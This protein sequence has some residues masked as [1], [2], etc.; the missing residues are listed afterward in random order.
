MCHFI[1][2]SGQRSG[3]SGL[4]LSSSTAVSSRST[5]K[6]YS[7]DESGMHSWNTDWKKRNRQSNSVPTNLHQLG[8]EN[9]TGYNY[10]NSHGSMKYSYEQENHLP[11]QRKQ[12]SKS[13][14]QQRR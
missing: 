2:Q 4:S 11:R 13:P 5:F 7:T 1:F 6:T 3:D 12:R 14:K 9:P 10:S 8:S